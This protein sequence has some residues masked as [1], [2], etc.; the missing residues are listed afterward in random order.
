[1]AS[2]SEKK[3]LRIIHEAGGET[4]S[5]IVSRKMGIDTG[6][7]RL[8]CMNLAQKDY[9]DL[10]RSGHFVITFKGK[11]SLMGKSMAGGEKTSPRVPFKRLHQEQS[12][13]GIM[14]NSRNDSRIGRTFDKP[15]QEQLIWSTAKVDRAGKDFSKGA[16][17]IRIGKLLTETK[18]P[19][20]YCRGKGEKP[21]G[22]ICAVCRGSGEANLAPPVVVCAYCKGGGEEKPRSNITCTVCRGM[23]F[24][25]VKEPVEVCSH[26][27]G[28]GRESGNKLPC[29]KCRGKGVVTKPGTGKTVP[30]KEVFHRQ[31]SFQMEQKKRLQEN[32]TKQKK[33]PTASELEVLGVYYES[34]RLKKPVN[35]SSS[36]RMSPAY[37][38]MLIRPLVENGLLMAIAPRQYEI[39][40]RG[41]KFFKK[42]KKQVNCNGD[43]Y[44]SKVKTAE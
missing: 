37:V 18:Y 4:T 36:T 14:S 11:Q 9:V 6:Y 5:H 34:K 27:R 22:T 35:V 24:V 44:R 31:T 19:C 26:C 13:W 2:G 1:M 41:E 20:G 32:P 25:C 16:G 17:G 42:D 23:G 10:K 43:N 12:G 7:A 21:K 33:T 8:L 38:S 30:S 29:L 3:A 15:G 39:T 40:S 28:T